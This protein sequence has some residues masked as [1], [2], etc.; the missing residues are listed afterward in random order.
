MNFKDHYI[1]FLG[2]EEVYT[3]LLEIIKD[4]LGKKEEW[5]NLLKRRISLLEKISQ[6]ST[7]DKTEIIDEVLK[8]LFNL[9]S[10]SFI[11]LGDDFF[12]PEKK[13]LQIQVPEN[14]TDLDSLL[15][16]YTKFLRIKRYS[17]FVKK[18]NLIETILL[19][20][21]D[22]SNPEYFLMAFRNL[23]FRHHRSNFGSPLLEEK[24]KNAIKRNYKTLKRLV[25]EEK[26][27]I[28]R[29]YKSTIRVYQK[30]LDNYF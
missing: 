23:Y 20:T 25:E 12:L 18:S 6:L 27:Q 30:F 26:K 10:Q 19:N 7:Q 28:P 5:D 8:P 9:T 2:L 16:V 17:K 21:I 15:R 14:T 29:E 3:K 24:I 22:L 13:F 11:N 4:P 1:K